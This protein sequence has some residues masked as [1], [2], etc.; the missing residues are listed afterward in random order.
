MG[1]N[2]SDRPII[3]ISTYVEA[4]SWGVW[5]REA[6]LLPTTYVDAVHRSG[7]FPVLL[8]VLPDEPDLSAV[9]GLV[10]AGGADIDPARYGGRPH[11]ELGP[12]RP[13]RDGWE[14]RLLRA[15]L[16]RDLP[17]LGVCRGAQIMNVALGG[18]LHQHLPDLVEHRDHQPEPAVFGSTK[19]ELSPGSR[20]AEILGDHVEVPCY[21]HQAIAEIAPRLAVTGRAGDGTV[22]AVELAGARFALGV[23]WHPEEDAADDRLFVALAAAAKEVRGD[24]RA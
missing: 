16:D 1:S 9:D 19:V 18:T 13:P 5:H 7:G 6:A 20:I 17:V 4:A 15:A 24:H 23:Q 12:T 21:H 10:L 2:A 8:P 14:V 22:E 3:G 11:A